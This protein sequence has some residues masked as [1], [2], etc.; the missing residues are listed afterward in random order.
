[1]RWMIVSKRRVREILCCSLKGWSHHSHQVLLSLERSLHAAKLRSAT[2]QMLLLDC[3][4]TQKAK[5]F[6]WLRPK[7]FIFLI[8]LIMLLSF[9]FYSITFSFVNWPFIVC[10]F[11]FFLHFLDSFRAHVLSTENCPQLTFLRLGEIPYYVPYGRNTRK[12]LL[13]LCAFLKNI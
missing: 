8:F 2:N 6:F 4:N 10:H 1:M 11:S 5:S 12:Y 9:C 13:N 3:F 7:C